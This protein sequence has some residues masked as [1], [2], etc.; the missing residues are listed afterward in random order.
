MTHLHLGRLD[1]AE[2]A[3]RRA[4]ADAR[5]GHELLSRGKADDV[6][7]ALERSV[8]VDPESPTS[9]A[10]LAE[11]SVAR[12]MT[13]RAIEAYRAAVRLNPRL[14]GAYNNLGLVYQRAGHLDEA[15][16]MYR[17]ALEIDP[18]LVDAHFNLG[19]LFLE[20][21]LFRRLSRSTNGRRRWRRSTP[22]SM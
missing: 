16:E 11:A 6:A 13:A 21:E 9:W 17:A 20:Q 14:A 22:R 5:L 10:L 8:A 3:F 2:S 1:S 15:E 7:A 18:Q 19:N 4:L 12:G